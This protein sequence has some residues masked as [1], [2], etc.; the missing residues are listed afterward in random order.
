MANQRRWRH[1]HAAHPVRVRKTYLPDGKHFLFF[2][3][4]HSGG[5]EQGVYFGSLADGSY[6]HLV[7]ADSD[8]QYAS[9][10]LLYH[11]QS[12]LLAQK[13]DPATGTLSGE[14]VPVASQV[15]YDSGTWHTTFTASQNGVLI[16][17]PGSKTLGTDLVWMDSAGKTVKPLA[18]RAFYKGSGRIS[19][20][21]KRLAIR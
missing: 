6:R 15:E 1:P 4:N 11:L 7:D 16:Y 3:T 14:P 20:D 8:A 10:Y 17:G 12:A 21:G 2:A 19:P 5:A 9:G 18:E 13:F